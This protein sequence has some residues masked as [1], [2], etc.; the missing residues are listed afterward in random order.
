MSIL[1]GGGYAEYAAVPS[2]HLIPIPENLSFEQAAA[3]PEGW[4]TAYQTL[5]YLAKGKPNEKVLIHAAASGVGTALIQ[6]AKLKGLQVVVT[7]GSQ[8]KISFC[9]NLGADLAI[10]Y[11][12]DSFKQRIKEFGGVDIVLDPIGA[13]YFEDNLEC[14][15][16]DGRWV[17]Y[18]TMGGHQINTVDLRSLMSKRINFYTTTLRSRSNQYKTDLINSFMDDG[19]LEGFAQGI[20]KPMIYRIFPIEDVVVAHEIMENNENSGKIILKL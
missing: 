13:S 2:D 18:G 10:N 6:M 9:E 20:L 4:L 11:K 16:L 7:C 8:E 3:I 17:L 19:I 14:L 1:P 15:N 5:F 12:T